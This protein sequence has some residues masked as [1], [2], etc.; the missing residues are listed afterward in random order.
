MPAKRRPVP[1][2]V[3]D[4]VAGYSPAGPSAAAAAWPACGGAVR[5]WVL[6]AAP[7]SHAHAMKLLS[8]TARLAAWAVEQGLPVDPERVLHPDAVERFVAV[9]LA[10]EPDSTRA[11][12]RARLRRV[13]VAATRKA[14]WSPPVTIAR[15]GHRAPYRPADVG[16]LLA[17]GSR[18]A[19]PDRARAF[20][21][22][23]VGLAAGPQPAELLLL[24]ADHIQ[25][26]SDGLVDVLVGA[27][28]PA[29]RLV[30]ADAAYG[31]LLLAA[32]ATPDGP[33]LTDHAGKNAVANLSLLARPDGKSPAVSAQRL[34]TTWLARLLVRVP[35]GEAMR[36]AG[37]TTACAL[38][39]L[40]P[41]APAGDPAALRAAAAGTAGH[42]GPVRDR[43]QG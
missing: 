2:D 21:M 12:Y 35:L 23:P 34:R 1:Q 31:P 38:G 18:I 3:Q 20:V 39:D 14:P 33:L 30:V 43:A 9:A 10:G 13:A 22:V 36:A 24:T 27:G 42:A 41:Y 17:A 7:Q 28:T 29:E 19:D 26:G 40:V 8:I 37:L 4:T 32:A 25:R 5:E 15:P 11:T 16:L 6:A